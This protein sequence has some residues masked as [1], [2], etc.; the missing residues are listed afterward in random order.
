MLDNTNC[1]TGH[2]SALI[3]LCAALS[4]AACVIE[5]IDAIIAEH[6]VTY[7]PSSSCAGGAQRQAVHL[8][9]GACG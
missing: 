7:W 2:A 1:R 5:K 8:G 3:A 6:G 4:C 9:S